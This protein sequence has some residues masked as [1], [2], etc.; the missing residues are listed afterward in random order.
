MDSAH[1]AIVAAGATN[2]ASDKQQAVAMVGEA[3]GNVGPVPKEVPAD[4]G[5]C[6]ARAVEGLYDLGVEPLFA[7][8]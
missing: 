5:Y 6:S 1:Q 2:V 8:E 4:A 7:P 3:I